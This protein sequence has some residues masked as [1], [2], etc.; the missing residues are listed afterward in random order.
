MPAARAYL[1]SLHP[2][3][4]RSVWLVQIGGAINAFGT[5]MVIPFTLIYLHNV[6][7]ISL[8]AAGAAV[9]VGAVAALATGLLAGSIVD[10]VGGRNTLVFG[11]LLQ[12]GSI[13]LFPQVRTAWDAAALLALQG[14][15]TA[16]FWPGQSTL[17]ARL[18]DP[19]T[20]HHAYALQRISIN[21]G[22][23]LGGVAGGLIATTAEP[24]SFTTL[25]LFDAATFL[26]FAV[27]LAFVHE[28]RPAP[29][30]LGQA[31]LGYREVARDRPF[32]ALLGLNVVF[33]A[34]GY[35]T[36]LLTPVYAKNQAGVTER[37]IGMIWFANT[38]FIV[39]AQM[40]ISKWLE[41]RRRMVALAVMNV[42]FA[43]AALGILIGG[44]RFEGSTAALVMI[45]AT[46]IFA[47]GECLQGPTQGALVADMAP[48]RLSGRYF[49]LSSMS[50]STGA[51][52]GP[53]I[54]GPLL[55]W[56]PNAVWPLAACACLLAGAGCLALERHLAPALR[57]TPRVAADFAPTA[58]EGVPA[59]SSG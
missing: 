6:R 42:C 58:E 35:E 30:P 32:I 16:C 54:G 55:G 44:T 26:A 21:L 10:R 17:L 46:L 49:A 40:P 28:P 38:L 31:R 2:H 9:G 39:L 20:R 36:L 5:G 57:R 3:L 34:A 52:L 33:V 11:L 23:G 22:I 37:W 19:E 8:A 4:P 18:A 41:G 15:G 14:A 25:Y 43:A 59:G 45:G 51:I 48:S 7:G 53:A 24:Q 47:V 56:K 12:A 27:V 13:A 1:R 50:W 29:A